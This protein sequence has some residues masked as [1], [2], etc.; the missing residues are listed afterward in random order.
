MMRRRQYNIYFKLKNK[1]KICYIYSFFYTFNLISVTT[2]EYSAFRNNQLK[3]VTIS[4][5]V[6]IIYWGSFRIN[7]I[8]EVTIPDTVEILSCAAFDSDTII[9]KSDS[10]VC[11]DSCEYTS[12]A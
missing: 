9:H 8:T 6:R 11:N 10:L 2:I 3:S 1:C 12:C 4:N 7:N 5:S